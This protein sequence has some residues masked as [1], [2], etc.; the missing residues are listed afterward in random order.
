MTDEGAWRITDAK[1]RRHTRGR[2]IPLMRALADQTSID[3]STTGTTVS[4]VW[5]HIAMAQPAVT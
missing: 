1:K 5:H 2:G 3:S 4:L